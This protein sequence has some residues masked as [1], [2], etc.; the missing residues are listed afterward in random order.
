MPLYA[1]LAT[2][3]AC[4]PGVLRYL[5]LLD[6]LAERG[7]VTGAVLSG[8]ADLCL[9]VLV[10]VIAETRT[11]PAVAHCKTTSHPGSRREKMVDN[12]T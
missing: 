6:L 12:D 11:V 8:D 9:L 10:T 4:V 7:T 3:T 5:D 1:G 2:E